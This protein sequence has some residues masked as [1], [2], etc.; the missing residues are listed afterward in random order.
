MNVCLSERQAE[1]EA[2]VVVAVDVVSENFTLVGRVVVVDGEVHTY[3]FRWHRVEG[4]TQLGL[5][6]ETPR[7]VVVGIYLC[8]RLHT[9]VH[10]SEFNGYIWLKH[11]IF[12]KS[13]ARCHT[14]WHLI[15]GVLLVGI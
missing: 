1:V 12:Y 8:F 3:A 15:Y 11:T 4:H 5:H 9:G 10:R 2:Y 13:P 7:F 14:E 6:I